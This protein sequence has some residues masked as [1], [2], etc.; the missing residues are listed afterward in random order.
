MIRTKVDSSQEKQFV[1]AMVTNIEFIR[2]SHPI[3]SPELFTAKYTKL[4]SK[5]CKEYYEQ[6]HEAPGRNIESIYNS[7]IETESPES[8]DVEAVSDFLNS[9]SEEFD[10]API[11]NV[12]LLVSEFSNFVRRKRMNVTVEEVVA[13]LSYGDPDKAA[14]VLASHRDVVD[15]QQSGYNPQKGKEHYQQAFSVAQ[16]NIFDMPADAALFFRPALTRGSFIGIQANAKKFKTYWLYEF[17]YRALR[18]GLKVAFFQVGDLTQEDQDV[19][20]ANRIANIPLYAD[21]CAN[22][23]NY[24]VSLA[25]TTGASGKKTVEISHEIRKYASP[26]NADT[27]YRAIKQFNQ[28]HR[29]RIEPPSIMFSVHPMT[30]INVK[31][32]DSILKRW[33]YELD[34]T[35]DVILIDYFDLLMPE[36]PKVDK[37]EQINQTW[38]AG[39]R[40]SQKWA[41]VVV[42]PTQANKDGYKARIQR[43]D[44]VSGNQLKNAHV[45]GMLGINQTPAE[46]LAGI[47]RLNWT[48]KR[49]GFFNPNMELFE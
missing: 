42:T 12:P 28:R 23:V 44:N 31:G 34:F 13:A 29:L 25:L 20:W 47:V 45:T 35:A 43:A 40:L 26:L 39:G 1:T 4:I 33:R 8:D 19:R 22:G 5:W 38:Q 15:T 3:I 24:P 16:E 46:K 17:A 21:E 2:S 36:N 32:I 14:A 48:Q 9:L 6:Y 10:S 27:A 49:K 41:A 30:T 37:L 11:L 7:W 18:T